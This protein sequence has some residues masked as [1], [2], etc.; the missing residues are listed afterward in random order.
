MRLLLEDERPCVCGAALASLGPA[1]M[2]FRRSPL[3]I[4]GFMRRFSGWWQGCRHGRLN[5]GLPRLQWR[6]PDRPG[7]FCLLL[8]RPTSLLS[9]LIRRLR[10]ARFLERE[11]HWGCMPRSGPEG[12]FRGQPNVAQPAFLDALSEQFADAIDLPALTGKPGNSRPVL[13]PSQRLHIGRDD[14][15]N[16]RRMAAQFN[17]AT[18]TRE[19]LSAL[20]IKG[21]ET[22]FGFS[23][24]PLRCRGEKA[25]GRR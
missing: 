2:L 19:G 14:S 17:M 25:D 9:F 1:R 10:Q 4:F 6:E 24:R 16:A 21:H 22:W 5:H 15:I 12:L 11:R 23:Q 7:F 20:R 13:H 8:V 18:V 3:A